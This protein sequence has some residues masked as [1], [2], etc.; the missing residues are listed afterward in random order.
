MYD[1]AYENKTV[2][3]SLK[4]LKYFKKYSL[5]VKESIKGNRTKKAWD[6]AKSKIIDINI[7]TLNMNGLNNSNHGD[8]QTG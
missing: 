7:I 5:E 1:K 4:K 6:I 2:K 8:C 3:N